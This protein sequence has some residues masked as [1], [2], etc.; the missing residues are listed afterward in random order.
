MENSGGG[1]QEVSYRGKGMGA[2]VGAKEGALAGREQ[3]QTPKKNGQI[4]KGLALLDWEDT[5]RI[6]TYTHNKNHLHL[7]MTISFYSV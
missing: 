4:Q 3:V 7:D 5:D 2:V 6:S 1:R